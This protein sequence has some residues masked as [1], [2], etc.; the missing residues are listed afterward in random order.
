MST[1]DQ[2]KQFSIVVADTGDFHGNSNI[3]GD[4]ELRLPISGDPILMHVGCDLLLQKRHQEYSI[5]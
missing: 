5:N 1:L 2:L 4:R 3:H